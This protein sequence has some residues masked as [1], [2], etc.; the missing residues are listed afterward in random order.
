MSEQPRIAIVGGGLG[1]LTA[2]M[3]LQRFG[4]KPT[5]YE[6]ADVLARI[7]AGINLYPNTTR[8]LKALGLEEES[9]EIGMIPENW[10][11]CEWDTGRVYFDQPSHEWHQTYGSP[12]MILHRGDLQSIM[13]SK[14]APGTIKFGA[15][16]T[17]L[18][19]NA[20]SSVTITFDSGETVTADIVIGADGINSVVR[21]TL[22]GPEEPK[23]TG[24]VAYRAIFETKL[25]GDYKLRADG[26]KYWADDRLPSKEDRH[27]IYYLLTKARDEVYFVTGSPDPN[28]SGG[29]S[30]VECEISEIKACYEGFHDE[31]QRIIDACPKAMKWPLLTR[32]PLPLWSRG[33][34]VLLGDAC[35]PMKPHM[36]QGAGMA[37]EDATVLVRCIADANGDF[38]GA[39]ELYQANRIDR[40]SKI[41]RI[42]NQNIWMRYPTDPTWCFGYDPMT[43]PLLSPTGAPTNVRAIDP[44]EMVA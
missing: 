10:L 23:Y 24:N 26:A 18:E 14:L 20:D 42:S 44:V 4:F 15:R 22:L 6:Q 3:L 2:A 36:G 29:A 13:A 5:V 35:H 38:K 32:D 7:G 19:E 30:P 12:H 41:Q 28:W 8:V 16:M 33:S 1:G 21:D 11:N 37:I 31:V 27:F 43:V 39:F 9:Y 40:A 25:L 34:V 17:G